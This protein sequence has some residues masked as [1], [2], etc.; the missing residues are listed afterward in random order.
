M[1]RNAQRHSRR[2]GVLKIVLPALAVI[3]A[4]GFLLQSYRSTPSADITSQESTVS[5]GK[6]V[7]ANPKLEGFTRD[8]QP[9]AVSALRAVQ[10]I[11]NDAV[12]ELQE[13]AAT[14][15][16]DMER[17]ATIDAAR[18]QFDRTTNMLNVDTQINIATSDGAVA[19]LGSALLDL[20]AGRM[21]T[22]KPVEIS[23]K[24]GTITADTMS[25]E[26]RG[27]IVVFDKRVRVHIVLPKKETASQ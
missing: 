25:V 14:V 3:M 26:D 8:N 1:F 13:I 6:L 4:A 7:M 9:Y 11:A 20:S 27:K 24:G 12:V 21:S 17:S 23:Y 2:V 5:D 16:I 19:T 15:P 22:D 18:G 10:D